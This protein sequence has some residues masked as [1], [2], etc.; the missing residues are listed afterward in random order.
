M[1]KSPKLKNRLFNE[2]MKVDIYSYGIVESMSILM[3]YMKILESTSKYINIVQIHGKKIIDI[4][5]I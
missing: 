5:I 2:I 3:L 4:R 1:G